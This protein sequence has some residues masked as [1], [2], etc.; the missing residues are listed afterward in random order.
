MKILV[1]K[2]EAASGKL[3]PE[4]PRRN[5]GMNADVQDWWREMKVSL[6]SDSRC[7]RAV[8]L[9][10]QFYYSTA[11]IPTRSCLVDSIPIRWKVS[12]Q[13]LSSRRMA[14]EAYANNPLWIL[15]RFCAKT[16]TGL[17]KIVKSQVMT[18]N[19]NEHE[20]HW[21]LTFQIIFKLRT[22]QQWTW[23]NTEYCFQR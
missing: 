3:V 4:A 22:V 10:Q 13:N 18:A 11:V 5:A 1:K 8:L 2:C 7:L 12:F 20:H 21:L 17:P 15:L 9:H 16:S 6:I 23:L 14:F 19:E